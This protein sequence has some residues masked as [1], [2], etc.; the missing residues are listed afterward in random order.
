[1]YHKTSVKRPL[2]QTSSNVPSHV[3]DAEC[4]DCHTNFIHDDTG[5]DEHLIANTDKLAGTNISSIGI[6][7]INVTCED[8]HGDLSYPSIPAQYSLSGT[9]GSYNPEFMSY[10]AV[11]DTYIINVT[12]PGTINV[13][14]TGDDD[15]YRIFLSLIGPIDA[16]S[17]LQDLNTHDRWG[18]TYCVPSV[19]GTATFASGSTIYYPSGDKFHGVTFDSTPGSGI[20]I[21]RVFPRSS[22]TFNYT[23]TSSHQVQR[24]PVIHIPWNCSECHNPGAN[25]SLAGAKTY[26]PMPSWDNQGLS[27]THTDYNDYVIIHSM[28]FRSGTALFAIYSDLAVI[29]CRIITR[30]AMRIACPAMRTRISSPR[31]QQA[32]TALTAT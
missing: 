2:S 14:V 27:Y 4:T 21:A 5:T 16:A 25:G 6:H 17:G 12:G 3:T 28:I 15:E 10:E 23:M 11:T 7:A 1:M 18:G 22:G 26:K 24:K 29:P 30:W 19:N 8:C 9:I 13:T 20:W 31:R 32:G